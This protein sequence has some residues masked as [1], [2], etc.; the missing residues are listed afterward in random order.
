MT[1][2]LLPGL[3]RAAEIIA[4][5]ELNKQWWKAG[6]GK[7]FHEVCR[8]A[9]LSEAEALVQSPASDLPPFN[10]VAVRNESAH[11][12][13]YVGEDVTAVWRLIEGDRPVE[14][15]LAIDDERI[16]GVRWYDAPQSPASDDGW[17]LDDARKAELTK[18][19]SEVTEESD[20]WKIIEDAIRAERTD[21]AVK[22]AEIFTLSRSEQ[23]LAFGEMTAQE[24]RTSNAIL[25]W[26]KHSILARVHE[27]KRPLP[28]APK[29]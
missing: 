29:D 24:M 18:S 25:T 7:P 11:F 4:D 28:P 12:T 8:D 17:K 26:A 10:P 9:V 13:E 19:L 23:L 16:I 21:E 2:P 3:R 27:P 22:C 6:A 20:F 15:A 5:K 14:I 1:H